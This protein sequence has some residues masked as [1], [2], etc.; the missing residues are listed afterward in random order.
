MKTLKKKIADPYTGSAIGD[1]QK[2]WGF[3]H[4]IRPL[5]RRVCKMRLGSGIPQR[6]GCCRA[7]DAELATKRISVRALEPRYVKTKMF[8]SCA[9]RMG[10]DPALAMD[11]ADFAN[12]ILE[13]IENKGEN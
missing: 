12:E 7:L 5:A 1:G 4:L 9:G 10:V 3:P 11:P 2:Q 6:L 13:E 8:D